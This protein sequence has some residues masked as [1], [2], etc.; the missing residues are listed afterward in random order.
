MHFSFP[1][2][3]SSVATTRIGVSPSINPCQPCMTHNSKGERQLH[4]MYS[5]F[6]GGNQTCTP[7]NPVN[8]FVQAPH[9]QYEL[10][11]CNP[12]MSWFHML[13]ISRLC[14]RTEVLE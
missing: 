4:I 1:I 9:A 11:Y 8:L 6:S 5:V 14:R 10:L 2:S 3:A 13:T 12:G 7:V